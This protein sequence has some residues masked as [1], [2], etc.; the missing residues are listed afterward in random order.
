MEHLIWLGWSPCFTNHLQSLT[1]NITVDQTIARVIY[2]EKNRYRVHTG[3]REVWAEI[4]GRMYHLAEHRADLPAVGDW[5]LVYL[6]PESDLAII[7]HCLERKSKFSRKEAGDETRE[8]IIA[9]NIDTVFLVNA[10]NSDFNVRRIE[11]YLTLAWESGASPVILL[12]KSDLCEYPEAFVDATRSISQDVP[13]HV[14]SALEGQGLEQLDPYF[15]IGQT[16]ALLG[17]SGAGKSTLLNALMQNTVQKTQDI[18]KGDDKGRHTTTSRRLFVLP[19]GGLLMDT[20]GMRELQLWHSDEGL[21]HTFQ[22]IEDL[23]QQ[24]RFVDCKHH[25][26]P[27]CAIQNAITTGQLDESRYQ[28]FLKLRRELDYLQ[29]K[30]N[31]EQQRASKRKWKNVSSTARERT[32]LKNQ[33]WY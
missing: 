10:L 12:T 28:H 17:S 31:T 4:S 14:L 25:Q 15:Q 1:S 9:T 11:R 7:Q 22:D 18:R 2:E 16:V 13:I 19:Q 5:V 27:G 33:D 20:P 24:C 32:R 3:E 8:Q 23:A 26:E 29:R 6:P 30:E 21:H